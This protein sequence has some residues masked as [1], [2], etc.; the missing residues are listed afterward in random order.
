M[1][2]VAVSS[3]SFAQAIA[4]G[5]IANQE[6]TV[7]KAHELGFRAIEFTEL[8]PC[9][10]AT[11]EQQMESA[12]RIKKRTD[13]LGMV[14]CSY[15]IGANLY[16]DDEEERKAEVERVKKQ[17]LI[18]KELGAKIMR[19]DVC[20]VISPINRSFDLMLPQIVQNIREVAT[21]A[22]EHGIKTCSE[23][24]GR[25]AQDSDR[26]ERLFNAVNHPNYGLLVDMGNFMC[27]DENPVTAVSRVAPYAIHAH[28]KDFHVIS[29]SQNTEG[30]FLTRGGNYMYGTAI[31]DGDVPVKKCLRALNRVKYDGFLVIEYEGMFGDCCD[32]IARGKTFLEKA[33]AELPT[34]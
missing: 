23:N 24:H 12:K 33:I 11:F 27:V 2:E 30:T 7:D 34:A 4:K 6:A 31:G 18:A 28:A 26:M 10:D 21:F 32:N 15:V 13:E 1:M 19:H 20:G 16:N 22:Q 3:Y 29:D 25:L 17:V 8:T 5:D 9:E 14:V